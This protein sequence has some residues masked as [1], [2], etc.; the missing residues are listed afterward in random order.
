VKDALER[1]RAGKLKKL[2]TTTF[3]VAEISQ[4]YRYFS[5]KDRIGKV[6]VSLENPDRVIP[7]SQNCLLNINTIILL[8]L[9]SQYVTTSID[10]TCKVP[11][12]F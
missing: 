9:S 4:A 6:V 8:Q 1:Y 3:D 10:Y 2:P 7:V 12:R 11:H 5:S